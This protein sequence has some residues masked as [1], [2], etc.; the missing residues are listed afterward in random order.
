MRRKLSFFILLCT[1]LC[2]IALISPVSSVSAAGEITWNNVN[3]NEPA[4]DG[5]NSITWG[6]TAFI[7]VGPN[8]T[9]IKSFDGY[10][11]TQKT[12]GTTLSLSDIVWN[13]NQYVAVGSSGLILTSNDGESWTIKVSGTTSG[14]S[15]IV[16]NG[17]QF[18]AVGGSGT[19][20]TSN[21]GNVWTQRTSNY[22]D[23]IYEISWGNGYFFTATKEGTLIS[24]DGIN[25]SYKAIRPVE[26]SSI[27][28]YD[29]IWDGS[30]Y[31]LIGTYGI[32][33]SSTDFVNWDYGVRG[34]ANSLS[35]IVYTGSQYISVGEKGNILVSKNGE[36][37][38]LASSTTSESLYDIAWNGS[39]FVAVGYDSTIIQSDDGVNWF[40]GYK[41]EQSSILQDVVFNGSRFVAVGY[42][43]TCMSLDGIN[44][45]TKRDSYTRL[46][47]VTWGNGLFVAVGNEGLIKTSP[48]GLLWTQQVSGT[49]ESLKYLIWNGD[50]FTAIGSSGI[51]LTSPDGISWTTL[52]SIPNIQLESIV[53]GLNQYVVVGFRGEILTSPD[54][55][56]WTKQVS[57][58]SDRFY[59]IT[60]GNNQYAAVVGNGTILTSPDGVSWTKRESGTYQ[61]LYDIIWTGNC[62]VACGLWELTSVSQDGIT[63]ECSDYKIKNEDFRSM[64]WGKNKLVVVG[65]YDNIKFAGE[66]KYITSIQPISVSTSDGTAPILPTEVTAVY[67]DNTTANLSVIWNS[68][69]PTKY[70]DAGTFFVSGNLE[71]TTIPAIVNVTVKLTIKPVTDVS[72]NK[73]S[74]TLA[75]GGETGALTAIIEPDKAT[76][77]T[78]T[79]SSSNESVATVKDGVVTPVGQGTAVITVTTVDGNKTASST[80]TVEPI[81][82]VTDVTLDKASMILKVGGENGTLIATVAPNKATNKTVTWSSSNESVATVK[83]GVVTPVGQG[84]AVVTVTTVDG[85]KTASSTITVEPLIIGV[86]DI[87]LDKASMTL[88]VGGEAETLI[89]TVTPNKATNKTVTWS[90][91]NESVATVKDGV[92]TPVGQGTAIISVTTVDGNKTA[93]CTVDVRITKYLTGDVDGSNSVDSLDFAL[94]KKYL[95]MEITSFNY[96]Y[97]AQAA[98][99]N[100]DGSINA[101][102]LA[103]MKM[104]LLRIIDSFPLKSY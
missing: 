65:Q 3:F 32:I 101:V 103:L 90:S 10:N 87:K 56:T 83:D 4:A 89:A 47:S 55:L 81:I 21:D 93:C 11:W 28:Y 68:I 2:S 27:Y 94:L 6:D 17:E 62:F 64:A 18:V 58:V 19:I 16:W 48:D 104:Y 52:T 53:Y 14:L 70:E 57:G 33:A 86:T 25:W 71:D 45:I 50:K 39:K 79:W 76:N 59:S 67:N 31:I 61:W 96:I 80:I 35:G 24:S 49:K 12:S 98:D 1:V 63:W 88:I 78:I 54:G 29:G 40:I 91:S 20:I 51:I 92:V 100:S 43:Q 42:Y 75:V 97:G 77:K 41:P 38:T 74:M 72:L 85:N 37:W 34:N 26:L 82:E 44:W 66:T 8:G 73:T 95:L 13:G 102:D 7:A 60:Y 36:S 15:S 9:I 84:T 46:N 23:T 22:T 30:K 69:D 99:V 5:L